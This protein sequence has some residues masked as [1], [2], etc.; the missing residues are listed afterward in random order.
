[1]NDKKRVAENQ[2][3][4]FI[5]VYLAY[6]L[7]RIES[8]LYEAAEQWVRPVRAGLEFRMSLGANEPWVVWQLHHL[9]N[10]SV[11]GHS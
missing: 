2:S 7:C 6:N 11:R 5:K 4:F 3:L 8:C 10:S 1:M 9:H